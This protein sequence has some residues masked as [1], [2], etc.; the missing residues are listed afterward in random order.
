MLKKNES[1]NARSIEEETL[2]CLT[3]RSEAQG[4]ESSLVAIKVYEKF[5]MNKDPHKFKNIRK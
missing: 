1:L 4:E 3:N 5:K 2:P